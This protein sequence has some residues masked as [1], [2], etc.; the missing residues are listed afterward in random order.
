MSIAIRYERKGCK[1]EEQESTEGLPVSYTFF[2]LIDLLRFLAFL[3]IKRLRTVQG[4]TVG[5]GKC[6]G[7]TFYKSATDRHPDVH[8][9][10]HKQVTPR[11]FPGTNDTYGVQYGNTGIASMEKTTSYPNKGSWGDESD[12]EEGRCNGVNGHGGGE[13]GRGPR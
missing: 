2:L 5:L 7:I 12:A 8:H 11:T 1:R 4:T 9:G 3:Q 13:G 6:G 10:V